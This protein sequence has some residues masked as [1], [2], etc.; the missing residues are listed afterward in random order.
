MGLLI[1]MVDVG[2]G[3]SFLLTIDGP[4]GEATCLST[5]GSLTLEQRF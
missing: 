5:Q 1:D 2:E 4:L 3:D